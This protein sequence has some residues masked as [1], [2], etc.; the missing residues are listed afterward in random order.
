MRRIRRCVL[1]LLPALTCAAGLGPGATIARAQG[2]DDFAREGLYLQVSGFFAL[3]AYRDTGAANFENDGGV[4]L[5]LGYRTSPNFAAEIEAEWVHEF[6][7]S[8]GAGKID[9]DTWTTGINAR[10][11]ALTGQV[12]PFALVGINVMSV[13]LDPG[14]RST[15]WAFRFGGG[16]DLYA[17]RNFALSLEATYVWGV[18]DVWE[19]DY[20][21]FGGG[22]LYRF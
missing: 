5:R 10:F 6:E 12:Q 19:A 11:F 20:A 9:T 18:G 22:V 15:D 16:L 2:E 21:T 3:E 8:T 7:A 4:D 14:G 13:D 17:T 1:A